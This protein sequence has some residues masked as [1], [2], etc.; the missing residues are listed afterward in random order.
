MNG[1]RIDGDLFVHS[2]ARLR[3]CSSVGDASGANLPDAQVCSD[4]GSV[5]AFY[6]CL[7][8]GNVMLFVCIDVGGVFVVVECSLF[9]S[10]G[11]FMLCKR[12]E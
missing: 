8:C 3:C 12:V 1:K 7:M 9:P 5:Y 6:V 10:F 2:W 11:C 4:C